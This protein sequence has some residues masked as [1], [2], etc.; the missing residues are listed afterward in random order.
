[1]GAVELVCGTKGDVSKGEGTETMTLEVVGVEVM[2]ALD[3]GA[4]I[5]VLSDIRGQPL[6]IVKC[7]KYIPAVAVDTMIV[8]AEPMEVRVAVVVPNPAIPEEEA[9]SEG[10]LLEG[11]LGV[12]EED[13]T[14][15][16]GNT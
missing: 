10:V 6:L 16:V 8:P 12:P 2:L 4:E 5:T 13:R 11:A 3:V 1:M 7:P 15:V 14:G 9:P